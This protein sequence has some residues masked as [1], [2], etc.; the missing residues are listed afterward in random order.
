MNMALTFCGT[1]TSGHTHR[2]ELLRA[3]LEPPFIYEIP[4]AEVRR[5]NAFLRLN[6]LG[7]ILVPVDDEPILRDSNAILLYQVT[8]GRKMP[9]H[10]RQRS[11]GLLQSGE[12]LGAI[13]RALM[14]TLGKAVRVIPAHDD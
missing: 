12:T 3:M 13:R 8:G 5:L 7:Q 9:S 2:V 4:P 6:P 1:P 10:W 14:H 11:A